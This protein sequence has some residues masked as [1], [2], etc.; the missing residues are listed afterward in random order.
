MKVLDNKKTALALR[1]EGIVK[2]FVATS[3]EN[4]LKD[5][6]ADE[7]AWEL[8]LVGFSRGDDPLYEKLKADIGPFYWTPAEAFGLAFPEIT[9]QPAELTVIAWILPQ[10]A[11]T[12]ADNRRQRKYGSERWARTRFYGEFFN[13]HLR[14][15]VAETLSKAG[16]EAVPPT[17]SPSFRGQMSERFGFASNWSERHGAFVSG[18]GTFGLCDGLITPLGKAMRCGTVIARLSVPSTERLYRDHQAYC[19]FYA[20]GTC[21]KCMKRC[22]VGAITEAGHDKLRCGEY[23]GKVAAPYA[24]SHYGINIYSCGLCQTAVPCES[25]IPRPLRQG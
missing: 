14:R 2:D 3:K 12:K 21:G 7:K 11:A 6:K 22:P 23:L 1:I 9:V 19:L 5:D 16:Y 18:L 8:P 15:H 13:D 20:R 24:N 17:L 10:T 25:A 4:S